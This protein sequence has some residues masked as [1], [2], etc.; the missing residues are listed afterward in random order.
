MKCSYVDGKYMHFMT[1]NTFRAS[2]SDVVADAAWQ[3][4]TSW[5]PSNKSKLQNSIHRLLPY[6]KKDQFKV[7][8][9]KK[10][11]PRME[12]VHHQDMTVELSVCLLAAQRE[13]ETLCI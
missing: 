9:V 7:S 2:R 13:I 8:R 11:V 6:W 3:A 4:I 12:M 1:A 5:V 10:D